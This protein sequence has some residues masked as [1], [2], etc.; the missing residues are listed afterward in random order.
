MAEKSS[1]L[2]SPASPAIGLEE[3]KPKGHLEITLQR[4]YPTLCGIDEVGRGC[5]AGPVC[6]AAVILDLPAILSLP[7]KDLAL[8]RDSKKLSPAQRQKIIPVIL[9]HTLDHQIAFATSAEI[10]QIN[11]LRGTFLAMKRAIGKLK[12]EPSML[13]VDG[14]QR[15]P[16]LNLPQLPIIGGDGVTFSI[17]AA[18]I[19]AK[20]ARDSYMAHLESKNPG[21]GFDKHVG[22]GTKYHLEAIMRLGVLEEHRKTFAPIAQLLNRP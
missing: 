8:I 3:D 9:R 13:L 20:E 1:S 12:I 6:A 15:I 16:D 18:S 22:Y 19:L 5:L 17:A 21:Y 10:D 4:S 11:I 7:K 2:N 14:N